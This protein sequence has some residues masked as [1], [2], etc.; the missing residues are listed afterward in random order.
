MGWKRSFTA[1]SF[2]AVVQRNRV[3]VNVSF[4][5][6]QRVASQQL[7]VYF[8]SA[9]I[10]VFRVLD[11]YGS[12]RPAPVFAVCDLPDPYRSFK[13]AC[14]LFDAGPRCGRSVTHRKI[15]GECEP[16]W[17]THWDLAAQLAPPHYEGDLRI[18]W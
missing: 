4:L 15:K 10:G 18:S 8:A 5:V 9:A 16:H 11:V 7:F 1:C 14:S 12:R 2:R 6:V 3:L 13:P 17:V